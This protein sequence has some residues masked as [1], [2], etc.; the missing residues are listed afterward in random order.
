MWLMRHC[1]LLTSPDPSTDKKAF[2]FEQ[3]T[4]RQFII[5]DELAVKQYCELIFYLF[6]RYNLYCLFSAFFRLCRA[7]ALSLAEENAVFISTASALAC[8]IKRKANRQFIIK[9]ELAVK[10]YCE[11]I[12]TFYEKW[13]ILLVKVQRLL[14][15]MKIILCFLFVL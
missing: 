5:K 4:N 8:E 15:I 13:F 1:T 12:F 2:A 11:L 9:D 14:L 3:K 10:Q 7:S 6:I